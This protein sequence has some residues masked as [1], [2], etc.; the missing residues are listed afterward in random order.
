MKLKIINNHDG[1]LLPLVLV[2]GTLTM[3]ILGGVVSWGLLNMKAARQAVKREVAVQIAESGVEYYRWHLAHAPTD[4]QD[5]TGVAGPYVH[6]FYDKSGDQIGQFTLEITPPPIGSSIVTVK[7]AG[8]S[9]T[10]FFGARTIT[11]RLAKPSLA[12]YAV[13][14]SSTMRF[15]AGTMVSG[16]I[17]SNGG[18]RF[19]GF[20]DNIITS[21]LASYNDP[22][23]T[24]GEEF[25]VHTHDSPIDPL[26]PAAVPS[27]PD[28]FKVGRQ[29]P[30]PRVDFTGLTADMS[31]MKTDAIAHGFYRANSGSL[32]YNVVL[33]TNDT[34]DL[35][36]V[37]SF[38]KKP[39][40]CDNSTWS[41]KNETA[42][43]NYNLPANGLIFLEDNIFVEGKINTARVSIVA[44]VFPDDPTTRK[45]ITVNNNLIYTN[46][47]GR[48]VISLIAQKDIN[49]GLF[50]QDILRIDAA[51]VAQK[52]RVGRYHYNSDCGENYIRETITLHGMIATNQRYGFAY[53]DNTGYKNRNIS[54][55]GNLLLS[56]PPSFPQT[57][58]QYITMSWEETK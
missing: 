53:T 23:H 35:S 4:Y 2:F 43:V 15:G 22:D 8:K 30:V 24:G 50:S 29:F 31:Q 58:D 32:G 27:R 17:H 12:K 10:N 34:F 47:D 6:Q 13:A 36:Q 44:A 55:D 28:V 57:S 33:K 42:P 20:T 41:I 51:L 48:D 46:Y 14:A 19:D 3:I 25:G 40:D 26:P 18:I 52:G 45:S 5:G 39:S 37:T 7:S 54:Y 56:P 38:K 11:M 9:S 1:M 21:A 16:P 49:V